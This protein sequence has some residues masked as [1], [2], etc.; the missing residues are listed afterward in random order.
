MSIFKKLLKKLTFSVN[1]RLIK[2]TDGCP[3]SISISVAFTDIYV[4]E[5]ETDIVVPTNPVFYERHV[6]DT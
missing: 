4:C 3:M 1:N 2:Q 6:Y 5:I